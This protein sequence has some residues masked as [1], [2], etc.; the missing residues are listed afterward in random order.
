MPVA[1][2][3]NSRIVSRS[4]DRTGEDQVLIDDD[5]LKAPAQLSPDGRAL[6]YLS[7]AAGA[8]WDIWV[9]PLDGSGPARPFVASPFWNSRRLTC[10]G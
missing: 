1:A 9:Q 7:R 8:T 3:G 5:Q 2:A 6:I 10:D 4:L